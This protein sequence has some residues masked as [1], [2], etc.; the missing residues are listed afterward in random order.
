MTPIQ[1]WPYKNA[2]EVFQEVGSM[3]GDEDWLA[4]VPP[5][6][7]DIWIPWMETGSGFGVCDVHEFDIPD[8]LGLKGYKIRVG[9]H[10]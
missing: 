3:G 7:L 5:N 2:P 1:V 10:A 8:H 6:F 4:L 9:C